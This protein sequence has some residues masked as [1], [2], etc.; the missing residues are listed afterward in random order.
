VKAG[1]EAPD[2]DEPSGRSPG[3]DRP[4]E[5]ELTAS[6]LAGDRPS[7]SKPSGGV[8]SCR[9]LRTLTKLSISSASTLTAAAGYLACLRTAHWGLVTVLLGTLLLALGASALNEVQESRLDARMQR[10]RNRPLPAGRISRL[11]GLAIGGGLAAGGFAILLVCHGWAPALLGALALVW[12]N[13]LYTP[14][15]RVTAFAIIPGALIGSLP[16]AI[17]WAAAGGSLASPAMLSLCL[18]FF[19]WQVPHFWMLMLLHD[20]DYGRAD[21]P[22]LS[23]HFRIDQSAR[24]S[25]TWMAA[26]A[27]SCAFM[28]CFG[29]VASIP[30]MV[31]LALASLWLVWKATALLRFRPDDALFRRTFWNINLYAVVLIFMVMLDPFLPV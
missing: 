9:D 26:T 25:F 13:G 16:P 12:Y 22:T 8:P 3:G 24:L 5:R 23:R 14:L 19:L 28:P 30:G 15:K 6:P 27:F 18:L 29:A 1:P 21:F 7:D 31:M 11:A 4:N 17:G 2:A 10:T 20:Q